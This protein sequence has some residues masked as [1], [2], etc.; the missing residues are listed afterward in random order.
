MPDFSL[1]SYQGGDVS[2][3][4]LKGK[5]V[6]LI[7]PR[8][9]FQDEIWCS[10]C[11]YQ[12]A[13]LADIDIKD[14]VRKKYNLEVLYVLPYGQDTVNAWV[15]AIGP[16]LKTIEE[17]KNPPDPDKLDERGKRMME[18]YRRFFPKTLVFEE[19]R[20]PTPFPIL[21]DGDQKVSKG[22]GL[23]TTEWGGSKT[24]Q[25]IPAMYIIDAG[26]KVVFKYFSQSTVDRP[27]FEYL[28]NIIEKLI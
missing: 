10:I 12:Y 15:D 25:N 1:T 8:G 11:Q 22:L 23:F 4:G 28:F 2:I 16:A 7:F 20:V 17:R 21:I 18:G 5:N 13:E 6:L 24:E 19:G 9:K 27:S 26:G 14:Q 3:S